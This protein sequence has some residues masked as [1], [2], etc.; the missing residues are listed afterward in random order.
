MI[1]RPV[2]VVNDLGLHLR[3]AGV[4][5]KLASDFECQVTVKRGTQSANAKSIMG[6][7]AL[8]AAVGT[9][10]V[11]ITD[12]VDEEAASDALCGLFEAGFSEE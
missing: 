10:L 12:G 5:A 2:R 8:A 1:E 9:E 11:L 4:L 3:A 6:L 7:L